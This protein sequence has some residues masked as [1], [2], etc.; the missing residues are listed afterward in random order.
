MA[1]LLSSRPLRR[2]AGRAGAALAALIL[3]GCA[4]FV[5][6]A[7]PGPEPSATYIE[8]TTPFVAIG[9]TQEHLSTGYPLHDNDSA[10]DAYVEVT[11][12]PPELPLFGRRTMEWA[13][14][15][16][17][18]EPYIHLGDVMDLS[19]RTEAER[20]SKVFR[21]TGRS[22]AILPGNHDGLMFGIYGYNVLEAVLDTDASKWNRACR[23]GAAPEDSK[24]KTA[25]E[26]FTKR[27]FINL[28]LSEYAK[29]QAEAPGL[30]AA[31]EVGAHRVS[32]RNPK[33][34][35]FLS[36]IEVK[37]LDGHR[38][39]ASFLTQ[40]LVLPRAPGANRNVVLIAM[41]TNQSGAL[42]GTW[43]V[44]M[45][46]SPGSQ[47]HMHPDQIAVIDQWVSESIE[48]GDIVVFA[49]HHNWQSLGLPTRT[50]LR[51]TMARLKHPLVYLSAH[52]HGGFWAVHRTLSRRPLL[53]LNVSSL[54]DWPIAYRRI[55]FAYDEKAERLL[56]RG[57]LLPRGD[58]PNASY[59]D[60][61]AAWEAETCA[62]LELPIDSIKAKDAAV[63]HKQRESRGTLVEWLVA[64]LAPVCESCEKPLYLHANSYQDGML[65][66]LLEADAAVRVSG[67]RLPDL[68][69]PTWCGALEFADC[70]KGLMAEEPIDYA[71]HVEL[72]RRKAGLVAVVND[73]LDDIKE[74]KAKA[75]MTCRAVQ[76]ARLDFDA[77]DDARKEHRLEANRK[78]EDF[79]RIEASIGMK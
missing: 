61:L 38:Y 60:L 7:G 32:W 63:V 8:L 64:A 73:Y 10:V 62:Q 1:L 12:R 25:R 69:L 71:A 28:Y 19:C 49:G 43:D 45:G 35:A 54:S 22:G 13:L 6:Q 21:A 72:F 74:P 16:F 68:K 52:T 55:S 66:T 79:F 24:H 30:R 44:L 78:A 56:V 33:P 70:A 17:P 36:A 14:Q 47:G 41:D 65:Q 40:R 53:E 15:R 29:L 5:P 11:Q 59:N 50:L 39:A 3:A 20:M 23:R 77:T 42:V 57:D 34:G 4:G 75:Y 26:A 9:D 27:D 67:L 18:N 46:R 31:P 2:L 58:K 51:S 37:L 76:A 48:Q